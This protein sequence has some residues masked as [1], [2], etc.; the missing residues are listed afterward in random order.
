MLDAAVYS[1]WIPIRETLIMYSICLRVDFTCRSDPQR[2][3]R[4]LFLKP[5]FTEGADILE[6]SCLYWYSYV[7][8][9]LQGEAQVARAGFDLVLSLQVSH[10]LSADTIDGYDDVT[11][12]QVT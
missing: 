5:V 1:R 10:A 2:R 9:P 8:V 4:F 3:L 6:S 12:G 11:L 7:L